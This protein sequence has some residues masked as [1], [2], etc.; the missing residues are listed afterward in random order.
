MNKNAN[1]VSCPNCFSNE[2]YLYGK[3]KDGFQK[4]QCKKCKRQFTLEKSLKNH[5]LK[6]FPCPICNRAV[7]LWHKYD[8]YHHFKCGNKNCK[9]SV[10][11]PLSTTFLIESKFSFSHREPFKYSRFPAKLIIYVLTF[12]FSSNSSFRQIETLL[13]D[14]FSLKFLTFPFTIG[15]KSL[16]IS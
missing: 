10:K 5:N 15:V 11:I 7:F 12:Y 14:L 4:Y 9:Y 3:D 16:L 2:I 13:N 8:T 1:K 6:Y